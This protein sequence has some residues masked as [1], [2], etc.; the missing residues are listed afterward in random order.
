MTR[1]ERWGFNAFH[2]VVAVTGVA[3]FYMKYVMASDDPFA[4]INHPWQPA[5][6]SIHLIAA[7]F[8]IAFF[9]M[10]FRSHSIR[11]ILS[12]NRANRRTGWMSL[13]SFSAMALSGY[14]IQVAAAPA[15]ITLLIWTHIATS[16]LF[17]VGYGIHIVIGYRVNKLPTETP[18]A[19]L[20][21]LARSSL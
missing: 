17:V 6:L 14:L 9:G 1:W 7:P 15:L 11:K 18:D 5:M 13:I 3:Y 16:T 12:P 10:L 19:A 2:S 21:E 8:F 20:P 4:I